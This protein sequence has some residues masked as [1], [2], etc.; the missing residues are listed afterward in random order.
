M[1]V[2]LNRTQLT[3]GYDLLHAAAHRL[4]ARWRG[5]L[6]KSYAKA[7]T[8]ADKHITQQQKYVYRRKLLHFAGISFLIFALLGVIILSP[9]EELVETELGVI[10]F[11]GV[12]LLLLARMPLRTPQKI[13]T[14]PNHPLHPPLRDKLFPPLISTWYA[15]LHPAIN[16]PTEEE[17]TD[18]YGRIGEVQ[19]VRALEKIFGTDALIFHRLQQSYGDDLDVVLI[20]PKGLWYF[21]VKYWKG[22]IRW[23]NGQW[24][25]RQDNAERNK[26]PGAAP[27]PMTQPPDEQWNR[28]AQEI[29]TTLEKRGRYVLRKY[30][31]FRNLRGGLVF[32]YPE[33]TLNISK[34]A[35][36]HWGTEPDWL[37][38][39]EHAPLYPTI[40]PRSMYMIADALLERHQILNQHIP[41][42]SMK[43][44]A[45]TLIQ[46][47]E[48]NLN[49]WE[50]DKEHSAWK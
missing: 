37:T 28:M 18:N 49:Q 34:G 42:Y 20:C 31:P 12:V 40:T 4:P 22:E 36:F 2:L 21:E 44:Y 26:Y 23:H 35:P 19:F 48:W 24:T 7:R 10:S 43:S 41:Q 32:N 14:P 13:A 39:L 15:H 11:L 29:K 6:L 33:V 8:Q 1:P 9:L 16:D 38:K 5:K 17:L 45:Q 47:V 3:A 25:R 46:G 30:P 27:L 50:P